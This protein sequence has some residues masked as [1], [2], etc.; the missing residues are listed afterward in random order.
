[1]PCTAPRMPALAWCS[2]IWAWSL[3]FVGSY[4]GAR[5]VLAFN[6]LSL[7]LVAGTPALLLVPSTLAKRTSGGG[8]AEGQ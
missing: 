5:I 8:L 3:P 4:L 6:A 2:I 7:L 1:M